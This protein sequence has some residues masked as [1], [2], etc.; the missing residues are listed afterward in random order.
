MKDSEEPLRIHIDFGLY[1]ILN[2]I[3]NG[4]RPNKKD[5]NNYI[6]FVSLINKL[7]NQDNDKA[8]LEIDEV[9]IGKA[10]D[11]ELIKDSFGEYKFRA[12]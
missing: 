11:Y 6:S 4:Y 12:L 9:N 2:R 5:N 3:L 8:A 7:I 10:A 1:D